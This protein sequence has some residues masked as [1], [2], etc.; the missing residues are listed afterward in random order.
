MVLR[1][2]RSLSAC[3]YCEDGYA[4][5]GEFCQQCCPHDETDHGIC[6]DCGTDRMDSRIMT[7]ESA[8]E[9]DR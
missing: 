1:S 9:G 8:F 2:M 7:A 5:T 3:E 6:L 4:P